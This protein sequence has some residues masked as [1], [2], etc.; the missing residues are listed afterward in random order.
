MEI[1]SYQFYFPG[2]FSFCRLNLKVVKSAYYAFFESYLRKDRKQQEKDVLLK[3]LK[4]LTDVL[5]A[6]KYH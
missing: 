1:T 6:N 2:T 5:Q 4:K 3:A